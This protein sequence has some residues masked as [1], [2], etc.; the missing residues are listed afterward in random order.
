MS[1]L[2]RPADVPCLSCQKGY[3]LPH[4]CDVPDHCPCDQP[5]LHLI[6]EHEE[7]VSREYSS[8]YEDYMR[9]KKQRTTIVK[10]GDKLLWLSING[11]NARRDLEVIGMNVS[12]EVQLTVTSMEGEEIPIEE[13]FITSIPID[14]LEYMLD[15]DHIRILKDGK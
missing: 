8:K 13:R 10:V 5:A 6:A 12:G 15:K 14:R 2:S 3:G 4:T 11:S 7:S 9:R 1:S